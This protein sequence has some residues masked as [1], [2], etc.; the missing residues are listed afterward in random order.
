M[1]A[2]DIVVRALVSDDPTLEDAEAAEAHVEDDS[3]GGGLRRG[4]S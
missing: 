2:H 4:R 1:V 3:V